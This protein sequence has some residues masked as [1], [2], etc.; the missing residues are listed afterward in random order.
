MHSKSLKRKHFLNR[1]ICH[2]D[3]YLITDISGLLEAFNN[4]SFQSR[5]LGACNVVLKKML[6]DKKVTIFLGL[7][8]ALIPAGMKKIISTMIEHRLID[9]LVS[10]GANLSHDF[11]ESMGSVHYVGHPSA[12]DEELFKLRI[13]R[14]YDTYADDINFCQAALYFTNFPNELENRDYSTREFFVELAKRIR[15]ADSI[16]KAA[17]ENDVPIFCPA[18]N[19]SVIGIGL[20]GYYMK[21]GNKNFHINPV[22]DNYEIM[23]I[24]KKS[25]A[26]GGIYLGGGV[27]KNYIQQIPPM[28]SLFGTPNKGHKYA[29]QITTDDP[30][31]GGLSGCTLEEAKSWGKLGCS[32]QNATVYVDATIALPLLISSVLPGIVSSNEKR[33]I[34]KFVWNHDQLVRIEI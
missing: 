15:S 28:L 27:P 21:G 4:T 13:D 19:D 33:P 9:V 26:T 6:K 30:K 34:K 14:I 18:L 20:T 16:I 11:Y 7:S 1:K 31:W 12:D 25:K 8:G 2:F 32:S 3:P 24:V 17:F 5:N 23:Q 29:I 10:T 22:R